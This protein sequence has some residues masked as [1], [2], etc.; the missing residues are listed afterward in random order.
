MMLNGYGSVSLARG[1]L[2][3]CEFQLKPK[4]V[5]GISFRQTFHFQSNAFDLMYYIVLMLGKHL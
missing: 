2:N 4:P 5:E 1:H 3:Q